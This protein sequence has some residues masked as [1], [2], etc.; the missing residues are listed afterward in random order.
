MKYKKGD[1]V[2]CI[3]DDSNGYTNKGAGWEPGLVFTV[4]N[5]TMMGEQQVL[6]GGARGGSGVLADCVRP[7]ENNLSG[8]YSDYG[9]FIPFGKMTKEQ[10][11]IALGKCYRDKDDWQASKAISLE[12]ELAKRIGG[13]YE[14]LRAQA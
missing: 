9:G 7:L 4:T 1:K 12:K 2:V 3:E 11:V 5:V 8:W 14:K 10:V 13:D 6:W